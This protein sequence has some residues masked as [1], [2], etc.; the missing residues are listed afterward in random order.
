MSKTIYSIWSQAMTPNVEALFEKHIS[1]CFPAGGDE[2]NAYQNKEC[3]I[4]VG[5]EVIQGN[6]S[7]VD[8]IVT[9]DTQTSIDYAKQLGKKEGILVGI[10]SGAAFAAAVEISKRE[11]FKNKNIVVI[12]PDYGERYLSTQLFD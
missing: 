8:E 7:V 9:V 1:V 11:E 10:S 4:E 5:V 2:Q 12:L 6:A 3:T